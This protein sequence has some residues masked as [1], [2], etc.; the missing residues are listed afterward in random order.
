MSN[1]VRMAT[2]IID[3]VSYMITI[4]ETEDITLKDGEIVACKNKDGSVQTGTIKGQPFYTADKNKYLKDFGL[5]ELDSD[6]VGVYKCVLWED[7][8]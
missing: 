2:V 1:I 5:K 8:S 3:G 6:I 7:E 4:P